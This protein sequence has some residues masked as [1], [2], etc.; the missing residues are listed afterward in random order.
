MYIVGVVIK[1]NTIPHTWEVNCLHVVVDAVSQSLSHVQLTLPKAISISVSNPAKYAPRSD[2]G[3]LEGK[4]P[5][6]GE[7]Y[8]H[9]K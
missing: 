9:R 1:S 6:T 2:F 8:Y 7:S 3:E 5:G 4:L